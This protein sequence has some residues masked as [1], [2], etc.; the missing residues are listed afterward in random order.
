MRQIKW[1]SKNFGL[2]QWHS[3]KAIRWA[4]ALV[5]CALAS[6]ALAQSVPTADQ[7]ASGP[8]QEVVVTGSRL[9]LPNMTSTSPIQVVTDKDIQ[10]SGRN[11]ISD[12]LNLLP[13]NFSNSFTGFSGRTSGLT[14]AG[15]MTNADLRGL[16]PQRT[17]VLVNGRRLGPAD[18]NTSNPSPAPDLDQIPVALIQRVDVVTGGAS[19][20][21][22][23]DA[24]AGVI[25]FIMKKDFEGIQIDGQ[26]GENWHEQHTDAAQTALTDGGY[27]IPDAAHDGRNRSA[28]IL[29]GSNVADGRGN[30]TGYF[31]YL[32][33]DPVLS[34]A[35]D[36][37][38]CQMVSDTDANGNVIGSHCQGSSNS[39]FFSSNSTGS[40]AF[41]VLGDQL[42]DRNTPGLNPPKTFNPNPFI[43]IQ[44]DDLR[45]TA[46]FLGHV[47]LN[48]SVKPYTEFSFMNDRTNTT[49]A[50][51]ALFRQ[52][53]PTD[54]TGNNEYNV[55]CDNPFLSA[56]E[57]S[58]LCTPAQI[59]YVTANPGQACSYV[60]DTS[61]GRKVITS[62]NCANV[63]IGRRNVEGGPR[64]AYFEHTNFRGVFGVKGNLSSTWTY[65]A[66]GQY[67]Y[68]NFFNANRKFFN[69]QSIDN[70]L[71][72][73]GTASNPTCIGSDPACVPY[74]IF[75][76]GGVTPGALQY[77]NLDGTAYG[78]TT[79]RIA[80]VD[81]TGELG[82]YGFKTPFAND[83]MSVNVGY[84]HRAD[85]LD[86]SPDGAESSGLLDGFGGAPAAINASQ[87]VDEGFI[88]FGGPLAQDKVGIKNLLFD[89]G[90]RHS[91]Y[92]TSGGV[93]TGKFE[94]QYQPTA[95]V[96]FRG[97]F[98]RA[99][100]APNL[101]ELYSPLSVGSVASGDDPCAPNENSGV[102]FAS[103]QQCL[104][105]L[106][107]NATAADVA[108][109]TAA[110]NAGLIPQG[111]ANQLSQA[112]GGN[113]Q[114]KPEKANSFNVGATLTPQSVPELTGSV[115][116]YQI[117][118]K[119]QITTIPPGL[120]LQGCLQTGDPF[121]CSQ[122]VRNTTQFGLTSG[123]VAGGGYINQVNTN[124]ASEKISGVDVQG[125]YRMAL[126]NG[127]G[128]LGIALSGSY[129]LSRET[130]PYAGSGTY[131]CAG[132]FGAVC[133]TVN[134]RWRHV[135]RMTWA[136]P[137]NVDVS[138]TW[139][140]MTGVSIDNNSSN[141]LLAGRT[142]INP[143]T[144]GPALDLL[145]A[146]IPSYSYLDLSASWTV[147]KGLEIRGGISNVLDKDPPFLTSD[148]VAGGSPNTYEAYDTLGRQL[149]LAF[150]ARF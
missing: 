119:D 32:K 29:I 17:L 40:G 113:T 49:I 59:A 134:P 110:Y 41:S 65:D 86:Y 98:Q 87:S 13:Q 62:P 45:Y 48:D 115:D 25:N 112:I 20:V 39:N 149:F 55:N 97:S 122:I 69:F 33:Q 123:G 139:R 74:D 80:H 64:E 60:A 50:P 18:P 145:N 118:L 1:L 38:A 90:F 142:F 14:T 104:R 83:G 126:G 136:T 36:F 31:T 47:D 28:S 82:Q 34:G 121:F 37:G 120:L 35:R 96:T 127:V 66:Y 76:D 73:T 63:E 132:L 144:G 140:F 138:A 23:S 67:Y 135:L 148:I 147:V 72:V 125:H 6:D 5:V 106:P 105:T 103:L 15:G 81:F 143:N 68:V 52:S 79:E 22:G 88:E 12:V 75:K 99:I 11:D 146:S 102:V 100:R 46:G 101:I 85:N 71:Q 114:L 19:A 61:T 30:V 124:I 70:A 84:E 43:T 107:K 42:V 92:S 116:Y 137:W 54:P 94:V 3:S 133:Q 141:P 27:P 16:G 2:G 117:T 150:T 77:L 53:N 10:T 95:D 51:T 130:E 4:T 111:S 8:I 93:N 131:D 108:A 44:R 58:V 57:Q 7:S 78:T 24:I 26:I 129:L 128:H 89:A 91:K 9:A 56:Q 21:Y 109:F